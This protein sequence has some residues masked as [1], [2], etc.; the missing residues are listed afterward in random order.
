MR[1][2]RVPEEI[3]CDYAEDVSKR[4]RYGRRVVRVYECR[5]CKRHTANL[6]LYKDDVCPAKDR[7]KGLRDRRAA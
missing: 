6:P 3:K 7:R 4:K 5:T 2:A 1:K